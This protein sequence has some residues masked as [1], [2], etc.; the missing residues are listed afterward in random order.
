MLAVP[1]W[2]LIKIVNTEMKVNI[3]YDANKHGDSL[4]FYE[5]FRNEHI[6]SDF[7]SKCIYGIMEIIK[8]TI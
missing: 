5:L 8:S 7:G 3:S 1:C 4:Y 2:N 6:A